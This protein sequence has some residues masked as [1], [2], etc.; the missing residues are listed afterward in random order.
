M[1]TDSILLYTAKV[2]PFAARTELALELSGVKY[3]TYEIDLSNKPSW[4][5]DKINKA[6]KGTLIQ[7]CAHGRMY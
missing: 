5:A 6:S 7:Q 1:T 4:Y 3:E 2:C